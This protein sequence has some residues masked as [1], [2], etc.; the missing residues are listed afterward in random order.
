MKIGFKK[1]FQIKTDYNLGPSLAYPV[2]F[3][4][5][6]KI[7]VLCFA[8]GLM[9]LSI[10]SW[11]IYLSNEIGGGYLKSEALPEE[12]FLKIIDKKKLQADIQILEN[13]QIEFMNIKSN[14]SKLVDPSL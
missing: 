10:F 7:M 14:R 5:H 1:F 6:W 2:H 8:I 11:R 13:K 4:K 3:V 12:S 9:V